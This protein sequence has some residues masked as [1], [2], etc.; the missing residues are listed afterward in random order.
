MIA[1]I[2]QNTARED[3]EIFLMEMLD[4]LD[5]AIFGQVLE[6]MFEMLGNLN[7][8]CGDKLVDRGIEE[9]IDVEA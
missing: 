2:A 9:R 6:K 3:T 1:D 4:R 8:L 7:V 5:V